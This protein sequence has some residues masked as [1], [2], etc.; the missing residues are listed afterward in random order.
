MMS[1]AAWLR[2]HSARSSTIFSGLPDRTVIVWLKLRFTRR[3]PTSCDC[4]SLGFGHAFQIEEPGRSAFDRT[5]RLR[6]HPQKLAHFCDRPT[7]ELVIVD[8]EQIDAVALAHGLAATDR[9]GD[10]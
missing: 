1:L 2:S 5:A 3:P 4:S 6:R 8:L 10:A 9:V 7:G